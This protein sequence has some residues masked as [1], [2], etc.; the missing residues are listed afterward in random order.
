VVA[1]A[2]DLVA[3]LH[4]PDFARTSRTQVRTFRNSLANRYPRL[5]GMKREGDDLSSM[6][7]PAET[8]CVAVGLLYQKIFNPAFQVSPEEWEQ[9][10]AER[11][12]NPALA[13]ADRPR[14]GRQTVHVLEPHL[15]TFHR[16]LSDGV[17][18]ETGQVVQRVHAFLDIASF[19]R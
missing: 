13:A 14:R 11:L 15:A 3:S 2:N 16:T 7:S 9:A 4:A 19:Q 10:L 8:V 1:A 6:M 5:V 17:A 18:D 12:A